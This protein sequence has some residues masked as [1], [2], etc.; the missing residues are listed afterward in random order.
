VATVD[1]YDEGRLA[2]VHIQP[3]RV[4]KGAA[5][6]PITVIERRDLSS[7]PDLMTSGAT[8]LLFAVPATRTSSASAVMPAGRHFEPVGGRPGVVS[9]PPADVTE[10]DLYRQP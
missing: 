5:D 8:V 2:L 4:V 3:T 9:G 6:G 1:T 10:A 7:V